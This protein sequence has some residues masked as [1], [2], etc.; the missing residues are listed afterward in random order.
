MLVGHLCTLFGKMSIQIFCPFLIWIGLLLNY[1]TIYSGYKTL[2]RYIICKY[3]L[4]FCRLSFHFIG[5][6]L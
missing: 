2:K 1:K 5:S 3:F 4:P 6:V